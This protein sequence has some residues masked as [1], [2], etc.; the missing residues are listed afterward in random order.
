MDLRFAQVRRDM[1]HQVRVSG[2]ATYAGFEELQLKYQIIAMLSG[3][4]GI[5]WIAPFV[6]LSTRRIQVCTH[7]F[8]PQ[9]LSCIIEDPGLPLLGMRC[10]VPILLPTTT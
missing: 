1:L 2:A 9:R 5:E 6:P 8:M 7:F 10:P 4:I 3:K